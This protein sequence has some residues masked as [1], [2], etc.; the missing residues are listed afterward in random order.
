MRALVLLCRM[1]PARTVFVWRTYKLTSRCSPIW[2]L[3]PALLTRPMLQSCDPLQRR[4]FAPDPAPG[5]TASRLLG[6]SA[7][8]QWIPRLLPTSGRPLIP[9]ERDA[10]GRTPGPRGGTW[11]PRV[12]HLVACCCYG[13]LHAVGSSLDASSPST[14]DTLGLW[15]ALC[16]T[17]CAH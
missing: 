10:G 7:G 14:H 8:A 4:R 2:G 13:G 5:L 16:C 15:D 9:P 11:L 17:S 3:E 6:H 1:S 12:Q